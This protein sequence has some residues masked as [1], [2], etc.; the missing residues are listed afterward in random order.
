MQVLFYKFM[1]LTSNIPNVNNI[2]IIHAHVSL[3][4]LH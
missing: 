1:D 4:M 3:Y 2:S